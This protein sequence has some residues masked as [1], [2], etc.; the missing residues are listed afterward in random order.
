MKA[1]I[2]SN[3]DIGEIDKI[4]AQMSQYKIIVCADGASNRLQG[5]GIIP[6]YILGDLDSIN[7]ETLEY[8]KEKQV[9]FIKFNPEKDFS[10]THICI[11][12]LIDRG[13][14]EIDLYG[15][16]GGRWD[17]SLA[18]FGMLYYAYE[19]GISLKLVDR[20]DR[21]FVCGRGE[22]ISKKRENQ[23]FSIFAVFEDAQVSLEGVKYPLKD[24]NLKRGESIGL[25][26]EYIKDCYVEIKKGSAIIIESLRDRKY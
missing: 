25:S 3:G 7:T 1:A 24:Y 18:N 15:A 14:K 23:H 22:C 8:F 12:F 26:N 5:A 19:K 9:Q 11:D 13:Y 17:H 16:L 10:D 20:Y 21:A 2:I 6:D 4:K